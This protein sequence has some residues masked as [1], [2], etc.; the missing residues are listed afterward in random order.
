MR[1]N[2]N[3]YVFIITGIILILSI[4]IV[5]LT[6]EPEECPIITQ[7]GEEPIKLQKYMAE[8]ISFRNYLP[9]LRQVTIILIILEF[10][11]YF[12]YFYSDAFL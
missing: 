2:H 9:P 7:D 11:P 12:S 4:S 5:T 8:K 6:F 1:R 10:D 3:S